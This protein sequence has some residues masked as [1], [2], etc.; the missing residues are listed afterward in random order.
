MC[1]LK[2]FYLYLLWVSCVVIVGLPRP[3]GGVGVY[4]LGGSRV[5]NVGGMCS[6]CG[7]CTLCGIIG[8]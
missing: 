1:A 7:L 8:R 6:R 5:A 3:Q 2:G 4:L